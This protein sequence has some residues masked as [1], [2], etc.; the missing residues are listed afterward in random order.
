MSTTADNPGWKMYKK[1]T[2][3]T[4]TRRYRHLFPSSLS[5]RPLGRSAEVLEDQVKPDE[6]QRATTEEDVVV[7]FCS[8]LD[9]GDGLAREAEGVGGGEEASLC[10]CRCT[11][12]SVHP[13]SPSEGRR[14]RDWRTHPSSRPSDSPSSPTPPDPAPSTHR[15][16]P[17]SAA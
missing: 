16:S 15:A 12:S 6:R 2:S 9:E 1:N 17:P 5:H 8:T 3:D 13:Y 10:T 14:E 11:S 4:A 7:G